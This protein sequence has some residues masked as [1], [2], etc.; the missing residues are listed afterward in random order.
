M[1]E[2]IDVSLGSRA[3]P[4]KIPARWK[5]ATI[6]SKANEIAQAT[7]TNFPIID[8]DSSPT[9]EEATQLY[10]QVRE[11]AT[12]A[13]HSR[14]HYGLPT[15]K[16][17]HVINSHNLAEA[18]PVPEVVFH[19]SPSDKVYAEPDRTGRASSQTS[20]EGDD[21]MSTGSKDGTQTTADE[22]KRELEALR[23]ALTEERLK[24]QAYQQ[25]QA[26]LT[27]AMASKIR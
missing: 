18:V 22:D 17:R 5:V 6:L 26:K 10:L 19:S 3:Y 1:E 20:H 11:S 9:R 14:K 2:Q 27:R 21:A 23:A 15:A 13:P 16:K 4:P 12:M 24:N 7:G 8:P 25:E